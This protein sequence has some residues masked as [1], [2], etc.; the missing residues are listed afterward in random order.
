[1]RSVNACRQVPLRLRSYSTAKGT[2]SPSGYSRD[3]S[4][5]LFLN[6]HAWEGLP[7]DQIFQLHQVRKQYMGN[8]YNPTNEERTAILSTINSL[9]PQKPPLDYSF[10]IENFKERLMNNTPM[11]QRGLP[12]K[13]SNQYV[14]SRGDLPHNKRRIE[15]LT[16]IS[17]FEM[18]LLA[19]YRQPYQPASK[20][21]APL[22]LTYQSDFKADTTSEYNRLVKLSV[23]LED[24]GLTKEQEHKFK[25]LSGD[26]FNHDNNTFNLKS[27]RYPEAAQN[28]T[29]LVSTFNRLLTESKDLSKETFSDIPLDK[30]HMKQLIRKKAN[31]FPEE[32]K[33]PQD[34]PISRHFIVDRLVSMTTEIIDKKEL[35]NVSP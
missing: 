12:Q 23:K 22:K 35:R 15:N 34:A 5:D 33:R 29:W 9:S 1:M 14:I 7:A 2:R 18:P 31:S 30:R 21:E 4:P 32:W 24:L 27:K 17:A 16:R 8:A 20:K 28:V 25:I 13:L 10:E 19:K 3:K 6:P 26:K 11:N